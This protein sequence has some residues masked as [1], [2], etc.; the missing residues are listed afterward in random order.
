MWPV[1]AMKVYSAIKKKKKN[2]A[3][4][5]T[6]TWKHAKRKKSGTNDYILHDSICMKLTKKANPKSKKVH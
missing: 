4:I 6:T 3:L 5:Q 2:E 1:H